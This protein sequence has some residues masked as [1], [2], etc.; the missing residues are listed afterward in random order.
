MRSANQELQ[1]KKFLPTVGFEPGTF[2]LRIERAKR[3]AIRRDKY[4]SP[5]GDHIIRECAVKSYLYN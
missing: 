2:R 4:Q 5:A 1:N 3:C